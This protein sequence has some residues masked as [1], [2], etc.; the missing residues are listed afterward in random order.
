MFLFSVTKAKNKKRN[1]REKQTNK[2][3]IK[4]KKTINLNKTTH[5]QK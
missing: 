2:Q 3:I 1:Q 4:K 5:K